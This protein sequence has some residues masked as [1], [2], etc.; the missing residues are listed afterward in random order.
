M[1]RTPGWQFLVQ[2]T[3][4]ELLLLPG[5]WRCRKKEV[6]RVWATGNMEALSHETSA[7]TP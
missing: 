3:E 1:F 2:N 4:Y 6:C 7:L 5:V